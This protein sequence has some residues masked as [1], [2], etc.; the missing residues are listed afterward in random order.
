MISLNPFLLFNFLRR[1]H[2]TPHFQP[3]RPED[4]SKISD[5]KLQCCFASS[6]NPNCDKSEFCRLLIESIQQNPE[7]WDITNGYSLKSSSLGIEIWIANEG[8]Y[9]R[10]IKP[11]I[12][13]FDLKD[14]SELHQVAKTQAERITIGA[15]TKILLNSKGKQGDC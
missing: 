9:C 2:Y 12:F 15:L 10:I 6:L 5:E 1:G 7:V 4:P 14:A 3:E 11:V 13:E 8:R